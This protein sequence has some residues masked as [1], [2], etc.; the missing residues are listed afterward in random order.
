MYVLQE[1]DLRP[2]FTK[3]T[4]TLTATDLAFPEITPAPLSPL[5]PD[6]AC[7]VAIKM[8]AK[9][10][11][12]QPQPIAGF[13]IDG[14]AML[15]ALLP[16]ACAPVRKTTALLLPCPSKLHTFEYLT[17]LPMPTVRT[18]RACLSSH[19]LAQ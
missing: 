6:A 12:E 1:F 14:L 8:E 4:A 10:V 7:V 18:A 17:E 16:T 11:L 5:A 13:F 9:L 3:P 19:A 2:I 15:G